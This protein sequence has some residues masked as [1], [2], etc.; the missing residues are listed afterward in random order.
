MLCG[1]VQA[2][3]MRQRQQ[4]EKL[5]RQMDEQK[6]EMRTR[7]MEIVILDSHTMFELVC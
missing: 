7:V 4:Y 1:F 3:I 6:E 5:C 2:H